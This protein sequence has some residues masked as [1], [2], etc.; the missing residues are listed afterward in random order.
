MNTHCYCFV[1][2]YMKNFCFEKL[3]PYRYTQHLHCFGCCICFLWHS[4]CDS[5]WGTFARAVCGSGRSLVVTTAVATSVIRRGTVRHAGYGQLA[6]IAVV[7]MVVMVM[8][9]MMVV[10]L[11]AWCVFCDKQMF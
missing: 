1:P 11:C 8:V 10:L 3:E 7:M 5:L 9:V 4:S 6:F 2:K